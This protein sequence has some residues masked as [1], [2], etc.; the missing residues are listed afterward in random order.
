MNEW[1][2]D[3]RTEDV[4]EKKDNAGGK[5][6]V[7]LTLS[8]LLASGLVSFGV[9][10]LTREIPSRP[11]W[12]LGLSFAAPVA[13]LMLAVFLK[14]KFH[15]TMTPSTSRTAQLVL[16]LCTIAAAA[17]VGCFCQVSNE[18]ADTEQQVK[19]GEGWSDV[20]IILDK[21]GSM[22]NDQRNYMATQAVMNLVDQMDD[23]T[24]VG[25]LIDMGWEENSSKAG[26]VPLADR[27]LDIAP[28][29][30][31]NRTEL[32][33]LAKTNPKSIGNFSSAFETACDMLGRHGGA[34]GEVCIVLVSDGDDVTGKFRADSFSERLNPMGVKVNYLYVA[35]E[36]SSEVAKL[37]DDT[38]GVSLYVKEYDRLLEQMVEIITVPVYRTVYKDALRDIQESNQAK[39]V[40]GIML[41]ILG[42]LIG[43]SLLIMLSNQGQKRFQLILS[44]LMSILAFAILAF[45]SE[46]I[47]VSWIREGIAFTCMGLVIMRKNSV[48]GNSTRAKEQRQKN[49]VPSE[50][51]GEVIW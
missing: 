28:L 15:P 5:W 22:R 35:P 20:L 49:P 50:D 43:F 30:E 1:E 9:A 2:D 29:T 21:S 13:F 16:A 42:L 36:Y 14:E 41:L 19:V 31:E 18:K 37:A 27:M 48:I 32:K 40:T 11:F 17:A 25:L 12:L 47:P 38:G 24:E 44:P 6:D 26:Q 23:S 10:W 33:R 8:G 51:P 46:W 34:K 39:T 4:K 3:N 7:G 45:G